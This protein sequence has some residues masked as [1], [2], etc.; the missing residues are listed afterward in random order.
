MPAKRSW[1]DY[2]ES[3]VERGRVLIDVGFFLKS[4]N[5]EIE[6]MNEDKVGAP[7]RYP[8]SYIQFL[9]F[10]KIGFKIP[11]RTVQGIVRGLSDYVKI[12]EMHF[13]HIR[14][15]MLKIKPSVGELNFEENDEPITLIVDGCIRSNGIKERGLHRGEMSTREKGVYQAAYSCR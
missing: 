11:Y 12:E 1:H 15:R 5:I 10:L 3:L 14:R 7:F 2:N 9:A 13:T 6:K 8:A 4:T